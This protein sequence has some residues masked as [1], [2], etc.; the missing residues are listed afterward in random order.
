MD[1]SLRPIPS[2][3][4]LPEPV[5]VP[6]DTLPCPPP[7]PSS[8]TPISFDLAGEYWDEDE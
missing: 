4:T 8:L 7:P 3:G 6:R 5:V 2:D 1:P